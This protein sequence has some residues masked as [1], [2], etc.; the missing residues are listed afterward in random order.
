[1]NDLKRTL[2]V[3]GGIAGMSAALC[4]RKLG[5]QVDL[6]EVDP[7][8]RVYGAGITLAGASL[9]A[10]QAL[11]LLDAVRSS[12]YIAGGLRVYTASG[13]LLADNPPLSEDVVH[14]GGGIMRPALHRILAEATRA[15]GTNVMLGDAV[16]A[17]THVGSRAEVTFG[18]GRSETYDLVVG[19]DGIYS[20]V[21]QLVFADAATPQR[22]GQSC[23]RAAVPRP[24]DIDKA[25]FIGGGR[26]PLG[27]IPVSNTHMYM[28]LLEHVPNEAWVDPGTLLER[29]RRTIADYSGVVSEVRESLGT[30]TP[31]V[32]R[33]LES[34]FVAGPWHRSRVVLLGDAV[35]ATTPHLAVGAG[36]AVEDAL[37]LSEELS[38]AQ[39]IDTALEAYTARRYQR[40][41]TIVE[42]SLAIGASQMQK[43]PP[44]AVFALMQSIAPT[45]AQP[46]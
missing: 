26:W 22:T 17:I 29:L 28:F 21:R 42:T 23:W 5:T 14:A 18:D 37:V 19:A 38:R 15:A 6:V 40:C 11:G 33:P 41:K 13:Q 10:L 16:R 4:L 9:R 24:R 7:S 46:Y 43:A 39:S 32:Y 35:H 27:L 34:I 25:T 31:I 8:W 30:D 36:L 45:L 2:I 1:M 20:Q 44:Y 3:G 12:G